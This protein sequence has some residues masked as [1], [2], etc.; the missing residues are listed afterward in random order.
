M[1]L[2]KLDFLKIPR[3]ENSLF[4]KNFLY[5]EDSLIFK[6]IPFQNSLFLKIP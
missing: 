1:F 4:L 6:N 5:N 3:F 2:K